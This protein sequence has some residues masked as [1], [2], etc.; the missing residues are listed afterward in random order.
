[1]KY[2]SIFCSHGGMQKW[3]TNYWETCALVLNWISAR[4]LISIVSLYRFPTTPIDFVLAFNQP[5]FNVDVLMD[6][7]L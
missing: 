7:P 4:S 6:I 2:K 1:M 3:V 5:E